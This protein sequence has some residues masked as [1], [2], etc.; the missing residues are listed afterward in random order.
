M[1]LFLL[2]DF[3]GAEEN[4]GSE[5]KFLPAKSAKDKMSKEMLKQVQHDL[6]AGNFTH[7]AIVKCFI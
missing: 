5:S 1:S 2:R 3:N 4:I 6:K 7:Q